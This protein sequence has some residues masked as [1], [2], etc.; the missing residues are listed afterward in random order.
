M[1]CKNVVVN[2]QKFSKSI[3]KVTIL[4]A[5]PMNSSLYFTSLPDH[6]N[7][8]FD[9]Q[10]HFSKFKKHNII[11]NA[12]STYGHC[13]NHVGCLSFKTVLKG[14]E[15]YG[16]KNHR[17]AVRPGQFLILNDDQNYSCNINKGVP[18]RTL[19]VFFKREFASS[20][21]RDT[22]NS[23]E[24]LLDNAFVDEEK[25]PEFFQTLCSVGPELKIQLGNLTSSLE[26]SGFND[27]TMEEHLIFLLHYLIRTHRTESIR[28]KNVSALKPSTKAE[29]YKRL[30]VAK[31]FL[32]SYYMTDIDLDMIS[33]ASC[34]SVPQLI[35]QFKSVFHATPH[36]YLI[37]IRMQYAAELLE[38]TEKPIYEI[39]WSCGFENISAFCRAF[40]SEYGVPPNG[41]RRKPH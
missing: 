9:E 33:A 14:E 40:K 31:D 15:W 27:E 12:L 2:V 26:K 34:L 13:D 24:Y 30:C 38:S 17:L 6:S 5:F 25:N 11:F 7:V 23:E 29:L 22:L 21:F 41:L 18:V 1:Y 19:S 35:R 3:P 4:R 20:V 39:A 37:S 10:L 8:G 36:Q 28:S 16:I 32:H